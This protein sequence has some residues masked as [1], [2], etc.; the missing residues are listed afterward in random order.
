MKPTPKNQKGHGDKPL[1]I[2]RLTDAKP[3]HENQSL[4]L[5]NA[6]A[7]LVGVAR[8]DVPVGGRW[9]AW[10]QWLT[11]RFPAGVGLPSPDLIVG[12]GHRT[13]LA[14]LAA[15]RAFGGRALVIMKPSLP[16]SLFDLCV[17]PEHDGVT[18]DNVFVTRGVMN[19]ISPCRSGAPAAKQPA[20]EAAPEREDASQTLILLGGNSPHYI[21]RDESVLEQLG[22][23]VRQQPEVQFVL[24]DSRRTPAGCMEKIAALQLPNLTLVPWQQTGPG[25]VTEQLGMSRAAWVSE[26]SVSMVYEAI[27]SGARVGLIAL[28]KRGAGRVSSGVQRLVETGWVTPFDAWRE[29]GVL[30]DPPGRFNEAARCAERIVEQWLSEE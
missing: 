16:L 6:L 4:G 30:Q 29:Q 15:R 25:W 3:G 10:L 26:D 27:T 19:T 1:V 7:S 5:C 2:W 9:S 21:W 14:L 20:G 8:H 28:E 13:H 11:G 23:I 12:A 17:V 18:G 22:G 24:S